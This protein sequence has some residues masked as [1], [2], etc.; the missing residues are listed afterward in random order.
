MKIAIIVML[1]VS[2]VFAS[3]TDMR[4]FVFDGTNQS[5]DFELDTSKTHTEYRYEDR[6]STC[7]RRVFI[8]YQRRCYDTVR[9]VCDSEGRCRNVRSRVCRDVAIYR[10]EAYTCTITVRV[11]IE[12]FDYN[13]KTFA[14]I[15]FDELPDG[16]SALE[17]F[18]LSVTGDDISLKVDSSKKYL[19]LFEKEETS[20]LENGLK[21][22]YVHYK[23]SWLDANSALKPIEQG[24]QNVELDYNALSFRM[25]GEMKPELYVYEIRLQQRRFLRRNID[26]FNQRLTHVDLDQE[27]GIDMSRFILRLADRDI[28]LEEGRYKIWLKVGLKVAA[29]KVLNASEFKDFSTRFKTKVKLK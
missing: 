18:K 27:L 2:S 28:D 29:N 24:I 26:K 25:N 4:E 7:F 10:R 12:V 16:A 17:N 11:P 21:T 8:G 20:T 3:S 14:T 5:L 15:D 22:I 1:L 9:R 19:I 23:L 6:L 13:V